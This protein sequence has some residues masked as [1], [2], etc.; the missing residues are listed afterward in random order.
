M[1]NN[2]AMPPAPQPVITYSV[3]D[4]A[5]VRFVAEQTGASDFTAGAALG[6]HRYGQV[7]GGFVYDN[8]TR[9]NIFMH[10]AGI[11]RHWLT[12]RLLWMAFDYP[13]NQLRL[14]RV[15]GM[16]AAGNAAALRFAA[17]LG[18]T[19]EGRLRR[20][21]P[22]GSDIICLVLWAQQCAWHKRKV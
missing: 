19:E 12:R 18:F 2:D 10:V 1:L 5:V 17:K 20:A 13:F 9:R 21:A 8:F 22:D 3:N 4:P 14:E 11:G 15:T 16:I 7:Q 6:V